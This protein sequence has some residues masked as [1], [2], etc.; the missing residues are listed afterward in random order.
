MAQILAEL[1]L[2]RHLC[3]GCVKLGGTF[4]LVTLDDI[5]ARDPDAAATPP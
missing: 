5:G 1:A 4:Q 3:A 2:K